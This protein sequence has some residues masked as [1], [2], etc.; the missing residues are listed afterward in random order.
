MPASPASRFA[1]PGT[2]SRPLHL[3]APD[4]LETW[5][6]AQPESLARWVSGTRFSAGAG[7]TLLLPGADGAPVAAAFGL[8]LWRDGPDWLT[9]GSGAGRAWAV[10]ATE[11]PN[12]TTNAIIERT[13]VRATAVLVGLWLFIAAIV[14]VSVVKP[15]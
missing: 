6:A 2:P 4:S 12:D 3:L 1:A 13:Y 15:L 10:M 14:V 11:G 8:A 7:E 5:L 9:G